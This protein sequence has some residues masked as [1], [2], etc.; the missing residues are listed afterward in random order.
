MNLYKKRISVWTLIFSLA[1][2]L[3][4]MAMT[5]PAHGKTFMDRTGEAVSDIGSG[6]GEAMSD[7]GD[8]VSDIGSGIGEAVSD[9]THGSD[10]DVK[11]SDGIIGNETGTDASDDEGIPAWIG[12]VIA[13]AIVAVVIIL[14][15]V[16]IPK[17]KNR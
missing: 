10:G 13:L 15:V 5:I 16:L 9:M 7:V 6:V 4:L 1:L 17:K 12:I 11:D 14:I 3:T 2:T 8:A